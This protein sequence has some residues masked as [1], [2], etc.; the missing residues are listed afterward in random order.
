MRR[1]T[2]RRPGPEPSTEPSDDAYIPEEIRKRAQPRVTR[3]ATDA[4]DCTVYA[5]ATSFAGDLILVQAFFHVPEKAAEARRLAKEFDDEAQRRG[6]KSLELD[7]A[8]GTKLQAELKFPGLEVDEPVQYLMW[9]GRTDSVQF[10]VSVPE[11]KPGS[12]LGKLT[13][14]MD[15]VPVGKVTFKIKIEASRHADAIHDPSIVRQNAHPFQ[16][17]FISYASEDRAEVLKRVQMIDR[18]QLNYF[19]DLLSLESGQEWEPELYRRIEE[20]DLFLLFWSS[21]S[22]GSQWV[23]AEV[24]YALSLQGTDEFASPDI[25][26]IIIEGPPVPLPPKQ[27]EHLHFNDRLI[28]FMR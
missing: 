24:E 15:G 11:R 28:Y 18:F 12:C 20:C 25:V 8:H 6:F 2:K 9:R 19:Q 23:M 27:L 17:A 22:K 26:P 3:P 16:Q 5:P 10:V 4:V 21:A 14:Y 13:V 7:V 1:T